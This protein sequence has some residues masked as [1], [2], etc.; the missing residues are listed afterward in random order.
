[1][2]KLVLFLNRLQI[3]NIL[4]L[5]VQHT[6]TGVGNSSS[7]H[8]SSSSI[9][10]DCWMIRCFQVVNNPLNSLGFS[11]DKALEVRLPVN[12]WLS[13]ILPTPGTVT[14]SLPPNS[15]SCARCTGKPKHWD[16][17]GRR[18]GKVYLIWPKQEDRRA[19]SLKSIFLKKQK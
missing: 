18:E 12:T 6:T 1:M 3:S 5:T 7:N 2:I 11:E 17:S 9:H 4:L 8:S 15:G 19:L 10:S 14:E 13:D 16:T